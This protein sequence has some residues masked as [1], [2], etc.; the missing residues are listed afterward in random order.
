MPFD[1][2]RCPQGGT[3]GISQYIVAVDFQH[4]TEGKIACNPWSSYDS[5]LEW[6]SYQELKDAENPYTVREMEDSFFIF[7]KS[8]SCALNQYL[9]NKLLDK[10]NQTFAVIKGLNGE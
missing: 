3:G 4:G 8:G 7:T 10:S 2:Q 6:N 5:M 1:Q 9:K